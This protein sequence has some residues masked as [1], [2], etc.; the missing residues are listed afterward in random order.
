MVEARKD[1]SHSEASKNDGGNKRVQESGERLV[2]EE[3]PAK[4]SKCEKSA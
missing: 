2:L 3:T 4:G 1:Q